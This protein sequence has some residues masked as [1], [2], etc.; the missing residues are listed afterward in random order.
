M[1]YHTETLGTGFVCDVKMKGL[2]RVVVKLQE[3]LPCGSL[4]RYRIW[5]CTSKDADKCPRSEDPVPYSLYSEAGMHHGMMLLHGAMTNEQPVQVL[6]SSYY[7]SLSNFDTAYTQH[8]HR[9][10]VKAE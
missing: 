4:A 5:L 10:V 2:H 8:G 3:S 7:S 9:F 1:S 6:R